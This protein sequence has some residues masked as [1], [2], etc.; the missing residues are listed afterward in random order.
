MSTQ[1]QQ[2]CTA[3]AYLAFER[4]STTKHEYDNGVIV[5]M[6]GA[7]AAHNIITANLI[8]SLHRQIAER[9]CT[10]F[11][12]DMRL[13]IAAHNLYTYPDVMV[14]CG[15][16]AYADD[17]QDI[18]LN[19]TIIIEVLSPSTENYDRGKKAQYY[20]TIPSLR[21]YL[22]IAQ[23]Q[24]HLEHFVRYS[25]YQWLFSETNDATASVQL[26]SIGC[27]LTVAEIYKRVPR[28]AK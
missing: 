9:E 4:T 24:F 6:A 2:S 19:P 12:S 1:P 11:P 8:A 18:L 15:D 13:Q 22:L 23:E 26:A 25:A 28:G 20:R 7:S 3:E 17:V 10:T 5:A 14:V 27:A 16:V 21:E